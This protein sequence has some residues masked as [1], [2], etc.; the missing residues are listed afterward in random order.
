[1]AELGLAAT[2]MGPYRSGS[3]CMVA[4]LGSQH[5]VKSLLGKRAGGAH[6]NISIPEAML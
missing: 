4:S 1:M 5:E 2:A 3:T 6:L